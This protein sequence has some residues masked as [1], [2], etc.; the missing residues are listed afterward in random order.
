MTDKHS[1]FP[2]VPKLACEHFGFQCL[3]PSK[4]ITLLGGLTSFG[5]AGNNYSLHAITEMVRQLRVGRGTTGLVLA[6]GG[7]ITYQHVIILSRQPRASGDAYPQENPLPT[8]LEVPSPKIQDKATGA[9][10]IEVRG[11][12]Y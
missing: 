1:C 3:N 5:G 11:D 12:R 8:L 10:T 9:A 7:W 6:N 2:I 4:P